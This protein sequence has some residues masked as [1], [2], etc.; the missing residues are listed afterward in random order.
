MARRKEDDPQFVKPAAPMIPSDQ[1]T[2]ATRPAQGGPLRSQGWNP[3]MPESER[4]AKIEATQK[5]RQANLAPVT[6][7][8]DTFGNRAR[9]RGL[10]PAV[11]GAVADA[12]GPSAFGPEGVAANVGRAFVTGYGPTISQPRPPASAPL[13]AFEPMDTGK[14]YNVPSVRPVQETIVPGG[15]QPVQTM[16]AG[17]LDMATGQYAG[18]NYRDDSPVKPLEALGPGE[19]SFVQRGGNVVT[20]DVGR[21]VGRI[22]ATQPTEWQPKSA[23]PLQSLSTLNPYNVSPFEQRRAQALFEKWNAGGNTG[24]LRRWKTS[25]RMSKNQ[26]AIEIARLNA[27]GQAGNL[28]LQQKG[29]MDLQQ[30]KNQ[31]DLAVQEKKNEYPVQ[32]DKDGNVI[33]YAGKLAK[34]ADERMSAGE[35]KA[36]GEGLKSQDALIADL[37]LD[38]KAEKDKWGINQD[39]TKIASL[40]ADIKAAQTKRQ[41]MIDSLGGGGVVQTGAKESVGSASEEKRQKIRDAN[42]GISDKELKPLFDKYGV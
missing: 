15:Y 11:G 13:T 4:L 42:P 19:A 39:K 20:G 26:A 29:V 1:R 5:W 36:F 38:L 2:N 34:P 30:L 16:P 17:S 18:T 12:F 31:G 37:N 8:R 10:F 9:E 22:D 24:G 33:G 41:Q 3:A 27:A 25:S 32:Y 35:G 40:E 28:A 14:D 7:S 6:A 21:I 23:Q